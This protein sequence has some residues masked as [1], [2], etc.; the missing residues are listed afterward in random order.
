MFGNW[1]VEKCKGC[2]CVQLSWWSG[3]PEK[4]TLLDFKKSLKNK[5]FCLLFSS[6]SVINCSNN[7]LSNGKSEMKDATLKNCSHIATVGVNTTCKKNF[8]T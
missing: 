1:L 7:E 8:K 2:S 4:F 5:I 3:R 6:R